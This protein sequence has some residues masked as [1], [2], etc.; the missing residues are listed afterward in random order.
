[1]NLSLRN[2]TT[3]TTQKVNKKG[4]TKDEDAKLLLLIENNGTTGKW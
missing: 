4:W 3:V 2:A 1:M